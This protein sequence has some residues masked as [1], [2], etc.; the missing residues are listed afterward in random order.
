MQSM[1]FPLFFEALQI[2]VY[3]IYNNNDMWAYFD[4]RSQIFYSSF[5]KYT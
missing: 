1:D 5:I 3:T 2:R 4:F